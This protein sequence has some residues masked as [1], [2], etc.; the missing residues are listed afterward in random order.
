LACRA[1]N[2]GWECVPL[3]LLSMRV[4]GSNDACALPLHSRIRLE[5]PGLLPVRPVEAILIFLITAPIAA[6]KVICFI[7]QIIAVEKVT[8]NILSFTSRPPILQEIDGSRRC[9]PKTQYYIL[10][11]QMLFHSKEVFHKVHYR[12]Q[13]TAH[14]L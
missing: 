10:P 14:H 2:N 3:L 7:R 5:F 12:S 13:G 11:S 1:T 6:N 4:R 9:N 8:F